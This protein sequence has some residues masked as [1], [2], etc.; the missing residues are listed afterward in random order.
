VKTCI[1]GLC[2]ALKQK[3]RPTDEV[4]RFKLEATTSRQLSEKEPDHLVV[5]SWTVVHVTNLM[6]V[7][8]IDVQHFDRFVILQSMRDRIAHDLSLGE[9]DR[10]L[11]VNVVQLNGADQWQHSW[12]VNVVS[13]LLFD[14]ADVATLDFVQ[15]RYAALQGADSLQ[16]RHNFMIRWW[17]HRRRWGSR[18]DRP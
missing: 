17:V 11:V 9:V 18:R 8:V 13:D 1:V 3:K 5:A 7:V 14:D 12:L 15:E 4:G 10:A 6:Q 16:S 2:E